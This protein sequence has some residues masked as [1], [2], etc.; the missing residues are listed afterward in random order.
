MK[1][2]F[3]APDRHGMT[4]WRFGLRQSL[5]RASFFARR[6]NSSQVQM[7]IE[8][9]GGTI[10][11]GPTTPAGGAPTAQTEPQNQLEMTLL[12]TAFQVLLWGYAAFVVVS[13]FAAPVTKFDD[14]IP[15]VDGTLVQQGRTPNLDFYSFYPPL[16]LYLDAAVF[17]LVGRTVIAVRLIGAALYFVVLLLAMQ[18]FRFQFPQSGPLLPAAVLLVAESIGAAITLPV[19]PGLAVSLAALLTY[20]YAQGRTRE[21]LFAVGMSGALTGLALLYRVNFGGYVAIVVAFDVLLQWWISGE[22]RRD[23]YGLRANLPTVAA[24]AG[25]LAVCAAGF[26]LWVYGRNAGTAV[27]QFVVTAQRLMS[28]RGFVDLGVS[29]VPYAVVL[30]PGWFLFRILKGTDLVPAKAFVPAGFAIALLTIVHF[31]HG[32]VSLAPIL[33]V[34]EFTAV[35]FFHLVIRRL[36]RSELSVLL[37][38]CCLL[39]YF[40]SRADWFHWR[41]LPIG[42]AIL[43]PFLIFSSGSPPEAGSKSVSK[44]TALAVLLAAIFVGLAARDLRPAPAAVLDGMRLMASV[45]R[46][47]HMSDTDHV[48]GPTPPTAA[49]ASVYSD[50]DE[51]QALRYLRARAGNADPIFVGVQ[52]H[53]RIFSNDLRMYWLANR[54]IGVRTFQLETRIASEASVQKEII[55][56]LEKNEVKWVLIDHAPWPGDYTF[57][58]RN[59]LGSKLLDEYIADHFREEARFGPYAVLTR[60][61]YAS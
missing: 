26:C 44:G 14:A 45:V 42:A 17:E 55:S 8:P 38:F 28:L 9:T 20:L 56:D 54:P 6:G 7:Q 50:A 27:F 59:Y 37:F 22:A 10:S 39:H 41:V 48:L 36:E 21:R 31:G 49:W 11:P 29:A 40:L 47:P 19:W 43:L 32:H 35:I 1:L 52:D 25:P 2:A 24:F 53:S 15:L 60:I 46:H 51:L 57:V 30:P 33:V 4:A 16:G 3:G 58:Q 18:L 23:R 34:L 61:S 12:P 5:R 13:C